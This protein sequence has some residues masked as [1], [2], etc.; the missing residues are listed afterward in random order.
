MEQPRCTPVVGKSS[1]PSSQVEGE[2]LEPT[3]SSIESKTVEDSNNGGVVKE[4]SVAEGVDGEPGPG[5]QE[6]VW[7]LA[8]NPR[9]EEDTLGLPPLDS[10]SERDKLREETKSDTSLATWRTLADRV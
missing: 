3:V 5:Q 1:E 7:K 4:E 10:G 6:A 8:V 9:R 2:R